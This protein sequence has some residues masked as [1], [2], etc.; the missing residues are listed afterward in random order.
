ML[1]SFLLVNQRENLLFPADTLICES[2]ISAAICEIC[3]SMFIYQNNVP[4]LKEQQ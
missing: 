4:E 1:R 3:G 2:F